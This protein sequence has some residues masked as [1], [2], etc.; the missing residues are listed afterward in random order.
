MFASSHV[1]DKVG[2]MPN[3]LST[4][5]LKTMGVSKVTEESLEAAFVRA[6]GSNPGSLEVLTTSKWSFLVM[7]PL[8]LV[9]PDNTERFVALM[10]RGE[11]HQE[12]HETQEG[13]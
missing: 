12:N 11:R 2:R 1:V 7:T 10:I 6:I 4:D 9:K 3:R 8:R 13:A 5:W